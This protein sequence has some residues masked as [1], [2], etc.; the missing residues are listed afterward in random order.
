[1]SGHNNISDGDTFRIQ[2][3]DGDEGRNGPRQN[4]AT[5]ASAAGVRAISAQIVAFYFR[6]PV[7]AFF[8]TRVDYMVYISSLGPLFHLIL[9]DPDIG[10]RK[11]YQ[12]TE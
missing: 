4:A 3:I 5:G 9:T 10:L 12:S 1:M 7:K 2:P 11:S 6:A 8:R